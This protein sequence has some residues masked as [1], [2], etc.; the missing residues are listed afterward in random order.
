MLKPQRK[1][2]QIAIRT[3]DVKETVEIISEVNV[4]DIRPGSR[5]MSARMR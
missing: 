4:D 2:L 3:A 5:D 1:T